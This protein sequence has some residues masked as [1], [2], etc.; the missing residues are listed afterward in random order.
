MIEY[1]PEIKFYRI[2]FLN[3]IFKHDS[4]GNT[5]E[6]SLIYQHIIKYFL[7][8]VNSYYKVREVE[9]KVKDD[10]PHNTKNKKDNP[11]IIHYSKSIIVEHSEKTFRKYFQNLVDWRILIA[12][13]TNAEKGPGST[14]EYKITKFG[15]L[16]ALLIYT[17]FNN[18]KESFDA[19]YSFLES[20]FNEESYSRSFL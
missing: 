14:F 15:H 9:N 11:N 4:S 16:L 10:I 18:S 19:L 7:K 5:T 3:T 1:I 2:P 6:K 8:D 12:R 13:Q 17:E 20:Y